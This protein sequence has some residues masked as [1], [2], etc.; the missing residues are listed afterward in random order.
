MKKKL[1][2]LLLMAVS[3]VSLSAQEQKI[4]NLNDVRGIE[5]IS[6]ELRLELEKV[7]TD[8]FVNL[9]KVMNPALK[10]A[11]SEIL[12]GLVEYYKG[13]TSTLATS[14]AS[15]PD[16]ETFLEVISQISGQVTPYIQKVLPLYL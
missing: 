12:S 15:G 13:N 6:E 16:L 5:S 4:V 9:L 11:D 1:F 2:L 10:T 14:A 8:R 3:V 7:P